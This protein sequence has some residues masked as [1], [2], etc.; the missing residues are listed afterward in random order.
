MSNLYSLAVSNDKQ[1]ENFIHNDNSSNSNNSINLKDK[2]NEIN[3]LLYTTKENNLSENLLNKNK[4][5][6]SKSTDGETRSMINKIFG[7]MEAGSIRGSIFNMLILTLGSGLLSLPG[8]V[9]H[10]SILMTSILIIIIALLVWWSLLLLSKACEKNG[11]Y[12]YSHLIKKLYGKKMSNIYDT[13][14]IIYSFGVLILYQVIIHK[15]IGESIYYLYYYKDYKDFDDFNENSNWNSFFC[16]YCLPFLLLSIVYPLC[17]IKDVAKLRFVSFFGIITIFGLIFLIFFQSFSYIKHNIKKN[18][19]KKITDLYNFYNIKKGFSS[20]LHIFQMVSSI[21]FA[22]CIHIG[23]IPIFNTLKNNVRRRMYKVVRRT[24]VID[25]FIF[26]VIANLGYL[27]CPKDTPSLIIERPSKNKNKA[28]VPMCIGRLALVIT[29]I[30]KLPNVYA[31]LRITL[32]D[33]LWGTTK[34]TN[35]KNYILTFV[36]IFFCCTVSVLY[37]EI[38]GYIKLM[39]GVCSTLVGFIFPSLLYTKSNNRPKWHWKNVGTIVLFIFLTTF[40]IIDSFHTIKGII[41]PSDD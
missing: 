32:F 4:S 2:Q 30:M 16:R 5:Y 41:K 19:S 24:I 36:V 17:L 1:I 20:D 7:P 11:T 34:I 38:N 6:D 13:I 18:G 29:L 8:Y 25:I 37:T 3:N 39:G 12:N 26:V 31:T 22:T 35:L 14:V 23:A 15:L 28:D 9:D 10:V 21:Y 33:K 40:G 27:T